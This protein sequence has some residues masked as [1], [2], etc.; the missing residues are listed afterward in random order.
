L[1][2]AAAPPAAGPRIPGEIT[3]AWA[4]ARLFA[5]VEIPTK[6]NQEAARR[7]MAP[8]RGNRAEAWTQGSLFAPVETSVQAKPAAWRRTVERAVQLRLL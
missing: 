1:E 3:A 4:Q 2:A 6:T 5:A 8:K 7:A